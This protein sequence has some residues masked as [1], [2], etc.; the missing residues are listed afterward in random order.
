MK[1]ALSIICILIV[2]LSVNAQ[3]H[4][5]FSHYTSDNGLSQNSITALMKDRKG[6]L[7]FGTRDGLNKFDGY[8]FT[9]YNSRQDRKLSVLSN[10]ILSIKEDK[11]GF[12]WVKTYDEIVYRLNP[13][14]EELTRIKHPDGGY[15]NDKIR[16]V[17]VLPTGV[18]WLITMENGCYKV[19]TN[20]GT[21]DLTLTV[22]SKKQRNI[23]NDVVKGIFLDQQ[24]NTWILT[25]GGLACLEPNGKS[26]VYYDKQAFHSYAENGKRIMLGSQGLVFLYEKR[27]KMFSVIKLPVEAVSTNIS[28]FSANNYIIATTGNGFFTYDVLRKELQEFSV[29]KHP[30]MKTNDIQQ[31]YIDR[32][33][34]AWLGIKSP[35]VLHYN[36]QTNKIAYIPTRMNEGQISN[37]NYLIFEDE[38]DI[39]WIQPY[40]GSFSWF[41]RSTN[42]LIPFYSPYNEDINTLFSYGVNHVLADTQGVLWISTNRG[43]GFFKCTFLPDYF[44]HYLFQDHSIYSISN[45]TRA[46]FEDNEK[47]LWVACKDGAVHVF[48]ENKKQIGTL[49]ADGRIVQGGKMEIFVYNFFQDNQGNIWLATKRQ[50]LFRLKPKSAK[51]SFVLENFVH[52]PGNPYSPAGNDFYSVTQ[53]H[54][55]RLWA[56]SY[57]AGLHLIDE[58]GGRVR[59]IH[60][61]N[62]LKSYPIANC[63]KVRQ[64]YVDSRQY[65][66]VATTEGL[67]VFDAN[68]KSLKNIA[69]SYFH[70][71]EDQPNSLSA[72][73]VHCI[74]EDSEANMWIGTFGGGLN[75]MKTKYKTGVRP[76]FDVYDRSKG[77]PNNV[78][79]TIIDD[80]AA[81][82]W[83]TTENSIVKFAKADKKVEVFGKGNELE[84]VE[85]SEAS[86]CL[87]RSGEICVGSKSGFYSFLPQAVQR[88]VIKAPLVFTRLF[89]FNKEVEI[90]EKGSNLETEIDKTSQIVFDHKQNV[91]TIEFAT[92]DM[93]A[94]E[95]IQYSY[96]LEGFDAD[97]NNVQTKHFATYTSLSPG[98]YT[99]RVKSTDSEGVW[100]NNERHIELKILPSFWQSTFA[101]FIYVLLVIG[102][103]LVTLYI[104]LTIFK[105]KNNVQ[106]E[107]QMTDMKLRFFTDISHELRTPLTLISL[108]VDH[109]LQ[110]DID[111]H[112]KA[113]LTLVRRNLDRVMILINQILDFRKIQNNKMRLIVEEVNFGE[114]VRLCSSNFVE[115]ANTKQ[116]G[117][118]VVDESNGAKV[119]V[120]TEQFESILSNLLSNAFKFTSAGKNITVKATVKQNV[121]VLSVVDEGIGIAQEKIN[122]IFD[123]FFSVSTLRNIAQKSTGIGLDLVK[124]LVDLHHGTIRVESQIG[125]GSTFEIEF[126]LGNEHFDGDVDLVLTDKTQADNEEIEHDEELLGA[127]DSTG[128]TPLILVVEDNDELRHFLKK[129]LKK[130]YKVVEAENG[131]VGWQKI[132]EL[133]PDFIIADLRMPEMDGLELTQKVKSDKR[134]S[135]I[136]VI[137]LTAVT[138][139]ESKLAAMKIGVDDYITKPFS[140]EFLQARIENLMAQRLQLQHF[141]RSQIV[142]SKP[143]FTLPPLEV[144]SQEDLFMQNLIKLMNDNLDNFDLNI[145]LLA[146]E[147]GMSRTVFFN[148]LKSLTGLSPVEFVRE[149]RFERAAEYIR[150]TQLTVSEISYQVGI[151][152][153]RYFSRCFKQK[154]GRTPSEYRS[155]FVN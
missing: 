55:G 114:Y 141:F 148:K 108:P 73:D 138:D 120:D 102:L 149:V 63:S 123:R 54:K 121:A 2:A 150:D 88:R 81:N 31:I 126:K 77:M 113:Q 60:A 8:N 49:N 146:T 103:F 154:F 116:I 106:L 23:P 104:F 96:K 94:P 74:Y 19:E 29:T 152:D 142:S 89:L 51:N 45:E 117:F 119:W 62:E 91:I 14:T 78:I 84:N 127:I 12:I 17:V 128:F 136:P 92:L 26:K 79:Y 133:M 109:I 38:K 153:P 46:L 1:K 37:P 118:N 85:F 24:K 86:A 40:F 28:C 107:K 42:S 75:K 16:D 35:G 115:I 147:L 122:F 69:F 15:V 72:N 18:I 58:Q 151:E 124:K 110:E 144:K 130:H 39:L 82:L 27:T 134:T 70:K 137:L 41:D 43:N 112:I 56:G 36:P 111:P 25:L 83:L 47:R 59:F 101:K 143:D 105:L 3:Y 65:I 145:D 131:L 5:S 32:A 13:S 76:E 22:F 71:N 48:D 11:W 20:E 135:H 80:N 155:Q 61:K 87:L 125:K 53:D 68:F 30:E 99:F 90:G 34:D 67:V 140:S 132:E 52:N 95:K 44:N 139:L 98:T 6:Y 93:R 100:L 7:W 21:K 129:S 97:W 57:G 66:W 33:G 4:F 10:R 50:G 9:V 64:V